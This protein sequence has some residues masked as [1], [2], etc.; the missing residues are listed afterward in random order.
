[1]NFL[2]D[3]ITSWMWSKPSISHSQEYKYLSEANDLADVERRQ[4]KLQRGEA[5]FQVKANNNLILRPLFCD[6]L[7]PYRLFDQV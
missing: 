7:E 6:L 3:A 5:P 2:V 4:R 1:M